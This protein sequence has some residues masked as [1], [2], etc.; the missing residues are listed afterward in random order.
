MSLNE[1]AHHPL[2]ER[3]IRRYDQHLQSGLAET[4]ES[5]CYDGYHE[6]SDRIQAGR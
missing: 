4:D 2:G 5:E 3:G 6:P 1:D